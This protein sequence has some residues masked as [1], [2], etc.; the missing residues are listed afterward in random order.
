MVS[1]IFSGAVFV[2]R[3]KIS[4]YHFLYRVFDDVA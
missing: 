4:L 3:F 2:R 1:S